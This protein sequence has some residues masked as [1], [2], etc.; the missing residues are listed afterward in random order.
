MENFIKLF[1]VAASLA[2]C[3]A[4]FGVIVIYI[5]APLARAGHSTVVFTALIVGAVALLLGTT[6]RH[7]S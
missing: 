7:S 2:L 1:V 3:L 5:L 6:R 4:M